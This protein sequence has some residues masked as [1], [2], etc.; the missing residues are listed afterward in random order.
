MAQFFKNFPI[1][2]YNGQRLGITLEGEDFTSNILQ[3]VRNPLVRFKIANVVEQYAAI[4]YPYTIKE[5]ESAQYIA[6]QYY[7]NITYDWVVYF[8]N[9]M[10]D[11]LFDW[12]MK[13]FTFQ[14]YIEKKY[15]SVEWAKQNIKYY[16]A[17][18]QK[19]VVDDLNNFYLEE[20]WV[21]ID[22]QMFI[23]GLQPTGNIIPAE[24]RRD[25]SFYQWE[26]DLNE[27]RREIRLMRDSYV[28]NFVRSVATVFD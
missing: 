25:L 21:N 10:Y 24:D 19:K 20:K 7:G 15:G 28:K 18:T 27:E 1:T 16:Q 26:F 22:E 14:R 2:Q 12:P 9:D 5:N 4:Y 17:R 3:Y 13:Y 11:P 23:D 6:H 8:V